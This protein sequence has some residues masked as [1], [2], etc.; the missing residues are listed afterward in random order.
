MKVRQGFVSNSSSSSFVIFAS[1]EVFEAVM[2]DLTELQRT[3][4]SRFTEGPKHFLGKDIMSYGYQSG[5]NGDWYYEQVNEIIDAHEENLKEDLDHI[6]IDS[7]KEDMQE[8]AFGGFG[9]LIRNKANELGE[10]V[11][12]DSQDW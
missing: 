3:I 4:V 12:T 7:I 6:D 9:S 1:K 8:F 11:L 10:G 2:K 5:N